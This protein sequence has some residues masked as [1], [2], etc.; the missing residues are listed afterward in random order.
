VVG[1]QFDEF[2]RDFVQRE[3]DPLREQDE[4]NSS[5]HRAVIAPVPGTGS[6]RDKQTSLFV[7]TSTSVRIA[8]SSA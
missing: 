3:T 1:G 6:L 5:Q 7:E 2:H 8:A 4:G